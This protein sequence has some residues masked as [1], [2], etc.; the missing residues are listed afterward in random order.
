MSRDGLHFDLRWI[1]SGEA[2]ATPPHHTPP[3]SLAGCIKVLVQPDAEGKPRNGSG[4]HDFQSMRP[5]AQFVTHND[6]HWLYYES[7]PNQH[8]RRYLGGCHIRLATFRLDG[9]S[10]LAPKDERRP[11]HMTTRVFRLQGS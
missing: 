5:A 7:C 6:Q 9:L 4:A 2:R 3:Y 1:Y 10:F 8:E 11:G